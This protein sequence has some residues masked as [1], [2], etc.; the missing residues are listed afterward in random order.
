METAILSLVIWA[1][2]T[3]GGVA[4]GGALYKKYGEDF[5]S[6]HPGYINPVGLFIGGPGI[7]GMSISVI[8]IGSIL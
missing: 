3:F 2:G 4:V 7:L 5:K 6:K 8:I 1:I